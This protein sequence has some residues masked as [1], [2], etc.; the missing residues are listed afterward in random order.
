MIEQRVVHSLMRP[1]AEVVAQVRRDEVVQVLF[2]THDEV[3]QAFIL[4][5]L[6]PA[7]DEGADVGRM[8]RAASHIDALGI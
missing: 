8:D 7:L 6:N 1:V 4:D 5:R 3:V 2:A